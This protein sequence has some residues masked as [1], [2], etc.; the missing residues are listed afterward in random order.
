MKALIDE[1]RREDRQC[2]VVYPLEWMT[3][4]LGSCPPPEHPVV[5]GVVTRSGR[6]TS[7]IMPP[8]P[9]LPESAQVENA[10]DDNVAKEPEEKN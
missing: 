7:G 2:W 5:I 3:E 4:A 9:S 10:D 6:G 1:E 8:P